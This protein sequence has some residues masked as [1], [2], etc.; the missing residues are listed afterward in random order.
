[1]AGAATRG[2][3]LRDVTRAARGG[4]PRRGGAAGAARPV[5]AAT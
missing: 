2:R 3:G 5:G 4:A 1:L